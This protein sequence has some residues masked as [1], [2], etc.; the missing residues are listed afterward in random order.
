[1]APFVDDT[2][3][4]TSRHLTSDGISIY[5]PYRFHFLPI[6]EDEFASYSPESKCLLTRSTNGYLRQKSANFILPLNESWSIPFVILL[7]SDYVIEIIEDVNLAM[8]NFDRAAYVDFVQQN[9]EIMRA[10]RARATSYWNVYHRQTYP[11]RKSYPAIAVLNQLD[12][13]AS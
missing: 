12:A 5:I 2:Y 1:M 6:S 11:D 13:W 8:P 9:R 7:L 4:T 3:R 10:T